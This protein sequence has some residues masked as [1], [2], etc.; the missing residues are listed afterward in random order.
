MAEKLIDEAQAL[1][2]TT[3]GIYRTATVVKGGRRFS[4]G[5]LVVVGDRHGS[6][7]IGYGKAPGVPAAIEKAQKDAKHTAELASLNKR[8]A[9]QAEVIEN[10]EADLKKARVSQNEVRTK[11]KDVEKLHDDL[12]TKNTFIG[13]LQ[14]DI[15]EQQKLQSQVRKLD[16]EN[17]DLR[18]RVEDLGARLE[19]LLVENG[20][21]RNAKNGEINEID[22]KK[23]AE[24]EQAIAKLT[25]KLKEYEATINTLSEAADSWKR[26]YDFLA[27]EAPYGYES[28][29]TSE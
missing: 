21:L 2:S 28:A 29:S 6:V 27:A 1:E 23:I 22:K 17:R 9:A 15:E 10:L 18:G 11:L 8:V 25:A 26:K 3:V 5:A 7:G 19:K 13:T 24:Q 12:E 20:E 14:K 16:I 4:F